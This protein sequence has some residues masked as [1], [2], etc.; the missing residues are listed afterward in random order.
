MDALADFDSYPPA[1]LMV[2]VIANPN[3]MPAA[4]EKEAIQNPNFTAAVRQLRDKKDVRFKADSNGT[5]AAG[6]S[7][8]VFIISSTDVSQKTCAAQ[9]FRIP[10]DI[11]YAG[12]SGAASSCI[13]IMQSASY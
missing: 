6:Q 5:R 8:L 7:R 13:S 2:G 12:R 1:N 11:Y 3:R 10:V 9:A 4:L